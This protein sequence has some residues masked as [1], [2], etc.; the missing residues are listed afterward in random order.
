VDQIGICVVNKFKLLKSKIKDCAADG[1]FILHPDIRWMLN[2]F[3]AQYCTWRRQ[4]FEMVI[5]SAHAFLK[6]LLWKDHINLA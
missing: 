1:C 6:I 5:L 3:A 4:I 2:A